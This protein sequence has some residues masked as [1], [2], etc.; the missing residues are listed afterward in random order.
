MSR[1]LKISIWIILALLVLGS[2]APFA[3]FYGA[4][5]YYDPGLPEVLSLRNL[6]LEVPL[7]IYTRDGKQIGEFGAERREPLAYSQISPKIIAAFV[8]AEDDR[9]FEHP[10]VDWQGLMRAGLKL[11]TSGEKSQGG[12][13]ITMQL[14]RNVYLSSTR[15]YERKTRE[16]FLALRIEQELS[17]EAILEIYL[18]KIF[19]GQRAYG[20]GSASQVYFGRDASELSWSQ[21]ALLAGLPKAPSRDN[22]I[23]SPRRALGRRNYVLR[24][25]R[26]LGKIS[27]AEYDAAMAEKIEVSQQ[28][29]MAETEASYVAEMV[30]AEMVAKYGRKAYTAGYSVYSTVSAERQQAA[31]LAL[32]TALLNYE[33]RHGWRGPEQRLPRELRN[34]VLGKADSVETALKAQPRVIGLRPAA[35]ISVTDSKIRAQAMGRR[36]VE[37]PKSGFKWARISSDNPLVQGD[38][39]R[40]RAQDDEW[41]LAQIPE[42][43]GALTAIDP[44]TGAIEAVVGGYD[45]YLNK[46]NRVIQAQRQPGS[47]FKPFLYAAAFDKGL[48]PATVLD[49]EP[50]VYRNS[51]RAGAW[52]P[53]NADGKFLGPIRLREAL[54]KS[55][56]L[57]AIRVLQEVGMGPA[58]Q[59]ISKFG[60]DKKR[61][62]RDLSMALGSG[63]FTPMEMAEAYAMLANGG[64]RIKPYII[65]SIVD[66]AGNKIFEAAPPALCQICDTR[67]FVDSGHPEK[68]ELRPTASERLPASRELQPAVDPRVVWLTND[69]LREVTTRGTGARARRLG[70]KDIAGKT[71]TTN[72]E[73]DAWFYGY[74]PGLVA[75][76]WVGFDQPA[77]LGRGEQGARAALPMWMDFMRVALKDEPETVRPRPT[78]LVNVRINRHSGLLARSGDSE[79]MM[80][81]VQEEHVPPLD[82]GLFGVDVLTMDELF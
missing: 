26:E 9:F 69:V 2:L 37:I 73:T 34:D 39:I 56:N 6:E 13:T 35:V 20:V 63:S 28:L 76:A 59:Y 27:S 48:T 68:G 71:G 1:A 21:A 31:N 51:E 19:L 67:R 61:I 44:R 49:D 38:I 53:Q 14:A 72:D 5:A 64:Y 29:F 40:I 58:R 30:R 55:R 43:Q 65:Q 54:I 15:S 16:I 42:V 41:R 70:R 10:G 82:D 33:E 47:G 32:R 66:A 62:P 25:L 17:K 81:V 74:N 12:S 4:R 79:A 36:I 52:R 8:A 45:F 22:P 77:P 18:N 75:V 3:I 60:L 23:T 11:L 80:E 57:V 24:R 7:R 50:I 78:G 46:Y